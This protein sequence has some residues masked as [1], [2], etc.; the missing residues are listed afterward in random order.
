MRYGPEYKR[1]LPAALLK[2]SE[3]ITEYH[4][5]RKAKTGL[6][7]WAGWNLQPIFSVYILFFVVYASSLLCATSF[8]YASACML[9]RML[10]IMSREHNEMRKVAL[11]VLPIC[12]VHRVSDS[13]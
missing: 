5:R 2:G 12:S 10:P 6:R 4:H 8:L 11:G 7:T 1:W 13:V 9:L 3:N